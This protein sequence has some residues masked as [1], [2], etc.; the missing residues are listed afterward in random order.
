MPHRAKPKTKAGKR[1]KASKVMREFHTGALHSGPSSGPI[2][3]K[4]NQARAIAMAVSG[5]ARR[6]AK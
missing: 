6:G 1:A 2:V 5:Q 3:R 4:R